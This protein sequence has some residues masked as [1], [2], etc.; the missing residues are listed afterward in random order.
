MSNLTEEQVSAIL[1]SQGLS[2]KEAELPEIT[3][4]VNALIEGVL[5]ATAELDLMQAEPWPAPLFWRDPDGQ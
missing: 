4:R 3:S 1:D 2:V 5:S